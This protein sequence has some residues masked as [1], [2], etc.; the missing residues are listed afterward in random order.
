MVL[1]HELTHALFAWATF[2][3]VVAFRATVRSGGHVQILGR[4]NWLIT[5]APYFVPTASL[6]AIVALGWLPSRYL[7]YGNVGLGATI[8]YHVVSTVSETHRHQPDLARAGWLFSGLFLPS[9]NLISLGIVV[10]YAAGLHPL[11]HMTEVP[12]MTRL[13]WD[14]VLASIR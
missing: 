10:S 5:V 12:A 13:V 14:S 11:A 7:L 4:G 8:A 2:H 3:R 9:A 6:L 1:E